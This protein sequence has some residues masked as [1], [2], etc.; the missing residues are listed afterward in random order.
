MSTTPQWVSSTGELLDTADF[1]ADPAGYR[2]LLG[3][4]ESYGEA[5]AIGVEGT[6]FYGAALTRSLI[7]AGLRVVEVNRPNPC[8]HKTRVGSF[9]V[10]HCLSTSQGPIAAQS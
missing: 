3:W 10:S 4:M 9:T 6:G 7:D 2:E 5:N 1:K 8:L